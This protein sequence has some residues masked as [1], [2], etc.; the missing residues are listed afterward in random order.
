MKGIECK[1]ALKLILLIEYRLLIEGLHHNDI[2]N[3]ICRFI[4]IAVP[5]VTAIYQ[6]NK[7]S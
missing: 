2:L 6:I 5:N 1:A 4:F 3:N 7:Y